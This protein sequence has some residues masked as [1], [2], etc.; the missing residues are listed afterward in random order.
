LNKLL[1]ASFTV[2]ALAGC[3]NDPVPEAAA[4][5]DVAVA[6]EAMTFDMV[7]QVFFNEFIPCTAG[8]DFS[9]ATVDAMVAEWR[10]S[11]IAGEILGA[12]GYA[13]ASENNRFQ[14]GWWELQWSSKEAADAGW[15]QWAESDV[16]QAWSS[17]YEN[18]MVC[19]AASRVSW[20]FNFPRDPYSFGDIDE[21]GRFV[22]AFL[23]CQL[24]DGKTMDDLN[25]A[26]AAYNTFLDAIPVTEN[27][28][29]SYGIYASNSDASE[30]EIYWGNFHP[31]FERMA[32]ADATWIDNGGET[33][34][35]MEAVMTCD[36]P[37]VHNA[38]L[39]Y[40]P[41]DPDFS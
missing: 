36:K 32:L 15:Q 11:G 35:Q 12:W 24:N 16:A 6:A 7:G 21:S 5:P 19:D 4:A 40:N 30:V 41:E 22:S 38:K 8:P 14:N 37:D 26:I 13:P 18:V 17:K 23:P 34:A 29:Y 33:K 20:D 28:F 2:L 3:S 1:A 10:A 27:S 39:F 25:I 31:S 9:E